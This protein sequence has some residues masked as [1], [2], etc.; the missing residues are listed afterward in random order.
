MNSR[1]IIFGS[2]PK[3]VVECDGVLKYFYFDKFWQCHN[4]KKKQ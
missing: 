3:D 2:D 1:H 4:E